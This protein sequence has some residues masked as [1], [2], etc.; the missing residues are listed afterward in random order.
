MAM[1]IID[2]KHDTVGPEMARSPAP[3]ETAGLNPMLHRRAT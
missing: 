3:A 1:Y 2:L